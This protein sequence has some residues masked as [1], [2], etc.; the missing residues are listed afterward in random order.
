[1]VGVVLPCAILAALLAVAIAVIVSSGGRRAADK[2]LDARAATV[3]KAWDAQGRPSRQRDLKRLGTRL[4]AQLRV[5]RGRHPK[6]A[7]TTGD[8][9]HYAFATRDR[10]TLRIALT[11]ANSSDAISKALVGG[12]I[13]GLGG[14][15]LLTMLLAG[16]LR[17]AAVSPLRALAG[18]IGKVQGGSHDARA[19]VSGSREVRAAASAF[20]Q[21]AGQT[22][23]LDRQ[24]G[25]DMLTGL[26]SGPRIRQSIGVEIKRSERDMTPMALV[27]L[28]VD[29]LKTV[30]D[31]HGKQSGDAMLRALCDHVGSTLRA[32]DTFGRLA[33][34]EFALILPKANA[35]SV[36]MIIARARE[37][38]AGVG[39]EGFDLSFSAGYAC[40]P[41]DA[42]D[43]DTLT[44]ASEG[45]LKLAKREGGATRRFDP[46]EVSINHQEGDR[47]EVIAIMEA[48]D[49]ITP[50]FQPLVALA[51]GRVSGYEALTRFKQPPKR[52]P[53]QWFNLAARVGMG[54]ALE[55]AAIKKALAVPDRPAGA[56]LSLNLSPSTL[57]APEV[58]AVLPQDLTGLV[59]EVTEHEL[60][61]DDDVLSV[62]LDALRARGARIAV[63]DAGA[64]YAGLQQLMRVA[65]DLIKLDRS[66]VQNIH[67]DPA[68]QALV[69]AFVRFGRRTGA[70][71]VAEGI[72]TEEELRVLADLD[73]TYG[74]GYFLAKPAPPWVPVS[75]WVSEKLLRRSLGG[76]LSAEDISK[77]PLGSDQRLAAVA[78][79]ISHAATLE[80]VI[81][82]APVIADEVGADELVL[83]AR[84]FDG[85]LAAVTPRPWLPNAGRLDLAHFQ[86]FEN[87]LRTGEPEQVLLETGSGTTT[88]MGEVALLANSGFGSML[89]IPVGAHAMMHAFQRDERP[90]GRAQ[91]NRALVLAY[92][93]APVLTTLAAHAPAA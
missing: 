51:T 80:D 15:L 17:G 47:H 87:V 88:G 82:L 11:T 21:V 66:L 86:T 58:E 46:S 76:Q 24:A 16:L 13:I 31:A 37:S 20:N 32:T 48:P 77:L 92:Q 19:P 72:E 52:F 50:V 73:V 7:V 61:A 59:I 64:G 10:R 68:K 35:D 36:E 89:A 34:D 38:I 22:A 5:V 57:R 43:I 4:N 41:T 65:P 79:R 75:P 40:F 18:A 83:F 23:E 55:A 54:G 2:E 14:V 45:A 33:G 9:R 3:K 26:P 71:V 28:D 42:R 63:D 49:G 85:S 12:L 91:T 60:A 81:A 62:D 74:Q 39:L 93:L 44:Q 1:M 53:D 67:E 8:V 6:V 29:D 27:L 84:S 30:N 90:W 78:A 25:M 69:D 70:Q 56:Y